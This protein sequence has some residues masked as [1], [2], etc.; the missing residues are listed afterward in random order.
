[1]ATPARR[2]H[3]SRC[4]RFCFL[5]GAAGAAFDAQAATINA[6]SC[7]QSAV[8]AAVNS[9]TA[10]DTVKVPAG[11]CTWSNFTL[12]KK[13]TLQG[14]GIDVTVITGQVAFGSSGARVTGFTF[15]G[16]PAFTSDGY[17]FRLDHNK[18]QRS[19]WQD[20]LKVR[21]YAPVISQMPHGLVDHNRFINSRVN[22]EGTPYIF[23]DDSGRNQNTLWALPSNFGG[24]NTVYVEDNTFELTYSGNFNAIDANYGGSF[25]AR[26][27][28]LYDGLFIETHSS[29]EGG[30][31]SGKSFE[32]YGNVIDLR[33]NLS[34]NGGYSYRMRGGTGF[35]FYNRHLGN[36]GNRGIPLDNVRS[37]AAAA[38][39]GLCNGSSAWDGNQN[40]SGWPC[41]DQI[42]RGPDNPRWVL[43]PAGAYTQPSL[44]AYFWANKD[45]ATA[46]WSPFVIAWSAS[47]IQANRDYYAYVSPFS[48]TSGVGCG[49][50][51]ARPATCTVGTAYWATN[52]SCSDISNM[53]GVNHTAAIDGT[54]YRCSASNTWTVHYK[55]YAYPHPLT[56]A[57]ANVRPSAPTNLRLVE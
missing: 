15:T 32:V 18:I 6:S 14:A 47:H 9:A 3:G 12:T 53:V 7:S 45:S 33:N 40:A 19:T 41:R 2:G 22:M 1:M 51:S 54:L 28:T 24:P 29:Q 43:S 56:G 35:I 10:G 17:G 49:A 37:Y 26:Y 30:N 36:W 52:Q 46:E 27:N 50:L 39:G 5:V 23:S 34:Q 25:V 13:I 55:P 21:D 44:P 48:G 20:A 8:Q 16:D 4:L 31:R 57:S 42:G 38:G 11:S